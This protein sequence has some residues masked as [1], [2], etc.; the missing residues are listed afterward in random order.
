[1]IDAIGGSGA[2]GVGGQRPGGEHWSY[3]GAATQIT[4]TN[5]A[6]TNGVGGSAPAS[7]AG[8]AGEIT[9]SADAIGHSVSFEAADTTA[10][11]EIDAEAGMAGA[12]PNQMA[13]LASAFG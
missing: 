11:L 1:M 10:P 5:T 2:S 7:P 12:D 9:S 6:A 4:S 3:G 13:G 8:E